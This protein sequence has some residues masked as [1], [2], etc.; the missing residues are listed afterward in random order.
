[1]DYLWPIYSTIL[2]NVR[3]PPENFIISTYMQH[4]GETQTYFSRNMIKRKLNFQVVFENIQKYSDRNQSLVC[5]KRES[6]QIC[7]TKT[8]RL[9]GLNADTKDYVYD[10][11][12]QSSHK[13]STFKFLL[14]ED[15]NINL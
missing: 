12:R 6:P 9:A 14:Q 8:K 10:K 1:M 5:D 13:S 4:I 2:K 3:N 11:N 7:L 15:S